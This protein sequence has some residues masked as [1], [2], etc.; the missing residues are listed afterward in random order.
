MHWFSEQLADPEFWVMISMVLCYGFIASKAWGP[1]KSGL[2][3]R[4][5][6]IQKRL[7]EA[8]ALR[9]EAQNILA[10]YKQRSENALNEAEEVLKN[11]QRR[12]EH[13]R[14]QMEKELMDSIARHEITAKNRIVRMEEEAIRSIKNSIIMTTLSHVKIQAAN[15]DL[16]APSID[17]SLDDIRKTLQK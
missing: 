7:D 3:T 2:D 11:A 16:G 4:A 12:A 6:A 1:I 10:E 9:I 8:E 15:Q 5:V 13:L 14:V 17:Q